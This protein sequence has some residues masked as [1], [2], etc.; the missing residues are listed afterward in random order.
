M[1]SPARMGLLVLG[2]MPEYVGGL[3]MSN[4]FAILLVYFLFFFAVTLVLISWFTRRGRR[5]ASR[6]SPLETTGVTHCE[7]RWEPSSSKTEYI[8]PC[9]HNH[10]ILARS[11]LSQLKALLLGIFSGAWQKG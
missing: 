6:E 11:C 7:V 9:F 2:C 5:I 4:S 10:K 1:V 8:L 3:T